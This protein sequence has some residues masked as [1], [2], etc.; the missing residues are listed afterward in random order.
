MKQVRGKKER[1]WTCGKIVTYPCYNWN[2]SPWTRNWLPTHPYQQFGWVLWPN[3]SHF[4]Y[5]PKFCW[6]K[7]SPLASTSQT[8]ILWL[9]VP[10]P[11]SHYQINQKTKDMSTRITQKGQFVTRTK[12]LPYNRKLLDICLIL[13]NQSLDSNSI[14]QLTYILDPLFLMLE[15]S[16]LGLHTLNSILFILLILIILFNP[17]SFVVSNAIA[18]II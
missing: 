7:T 2:L 5:I 8:Q 15:K 4:R 12:K 13:A 16:F 17:T 11:M 9:D 14:I 6:S 1:R 18:L 10:T 3:V